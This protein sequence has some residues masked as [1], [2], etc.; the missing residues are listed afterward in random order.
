[1][2]RRRDIMHSAVFGSFVLRG[3]YKHLNGEF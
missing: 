3:A 1:M 2:C